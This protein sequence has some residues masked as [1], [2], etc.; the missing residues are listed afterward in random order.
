MLLKH[1]TRSQHYALAHRTH[2]LIL[3]GSFYPDLSSSLG[4]QM[5]IYEHTSWSEPQPPLF[6]TNLCILQED[7]GNVLEVHYY[8]HSKTCKAY[9]CY[10]IS[11]H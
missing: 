4:L 11:K 5:S 2:S 3:H 10:R 9:Q 7:Q 8:N 1:I 6:Q